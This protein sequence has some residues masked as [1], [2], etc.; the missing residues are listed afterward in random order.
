M[1]S[2][3]SFLGALGVPSFSVFRG[4]GLGVRVPAWDV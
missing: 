3:F 4:S 2:P 1:E